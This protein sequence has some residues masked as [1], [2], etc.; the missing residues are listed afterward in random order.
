M[1]DKHIATNNNN[2][3]VS[4]LI[5]GIGLLAVVMA[6]SQYAFRRGKPVCSH[7]ILNTYMY[8]VASL[9]I[10]SLFVIGLERYPGLNPY[11]YT[12]LSNRG[13]G[14]V[15]WLL[16]LVAVLLVLFITMNINPNKVFSKHFSWIVLLYLLSIIFY[17]SYYLSREMNLFFST[18]ATVGVM[19][20]LLTLFAFLKPEW[21]SLD[22]GPVLLVALV[23]AIVLHLIMIFSGIAWNR[24]GLAKWLAWFLVF[25]FSAFILYDTKKLQVLATRCRVDS[26]NRLERPDY[27]NHSLGFLLDLLNLFISLLRGQALN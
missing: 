24:G 16:M 23:A 12:N 26:N 20:V 13:L 25:L 22:W 18:L 5:F 14:L 11:H 19:M 6:I 10:I 21:I 17:P 27:I 2:S 1:S 9:L 4:I 3:N 7:F 8:V 15:S